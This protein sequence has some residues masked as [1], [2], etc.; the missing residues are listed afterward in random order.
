M[1]KSSDPRTGYITLRFAK[2]GLDISTI[3]DFL[4][5]LVRTDPRNALPEGDN[6]PIWEEP[7]VGVAAAW[8]P[9]S[10]L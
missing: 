8:I 3:T 2:T 9:C 7:V 4:N 5:E 6:M 10:R 1:S